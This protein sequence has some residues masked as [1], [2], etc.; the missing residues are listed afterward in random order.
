MTKVTVTHVLDQNSYLKRAILSAMGAGPDGQR[1]ADAFR[2]AGDDGLEIVLEIA[3]IRLDA[4]RFFGNFQ[5]AMEEIIA[6]AA[7]AL[8]TEKLGTAM[9][10]V[11]QLHEDLVAKSRVLFGVPKEVW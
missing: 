3:G 6:V 7:A 4:C 2:A 9:D 10:E 11:A 1:V 8:V 5:A